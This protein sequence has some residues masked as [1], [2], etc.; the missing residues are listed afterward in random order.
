LPETRQDNTRPTFDDPDLL[1]RRT[2]A[3]IGAAVEP[4]LEHLTTFSAL[5]QH[6][7]Q[8]RNITKYT[9]LDEITI[10]HFVDSLQALR[11]PFL[12]GDERVVD[13]GT[14]PGLPGIPCALVHPAWEITLVDSRK[15]NGDF[16]RS[17]CDQLLAVRARVVIG[18]AEALAHDPLYRAQYDLALARAVTPFPQLIELA[19]P[20]LKEGGHLL[21]HRGADWQQEVKQARDAFTTLG[22]VLTHSV[23]YTLPG[24]DGEWAVLAIQR[25]GILPRNYPRSPGRIRKNP[26]T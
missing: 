4:C 12:R 5:L 13:I 14:G 16:L 8:N 18:R 23:L 6:E 15:K 26:L 11:F 20:F 9:T 17:V 7:A 10:F 24:R 25:L 19:L 2:L 22:G 21:A 1:L 3:D